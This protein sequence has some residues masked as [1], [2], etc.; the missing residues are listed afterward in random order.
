MGFSVIHGSPQHKWVPVEPGEVI[1][2]GSIVGVD[3]ATP[4]EGVQPLPSASGVSNATNAD[5]PFGI[6]VG[7]NNVEGNLAYST[8]YNTEYITQVAAGDVY[9]STTQYRGVEGVFSKGDP[10]AMVKVAIID[11]TTV[12]RGQLYDTSFGT[13]PTVNTVSVASGSDGIGCSTDAATVAT[14]ANFSTIYARSGANMGIYRTLTSNSTTAHTWLK[15]MKSDM[16]VGDTAVILN[17]LRPYGISL[18]Q[19]DSEAQFVDVNAALSSDYFYVNVLNLDLSEAG[20]EFIDFQFN[21][22][23][24]C[25]TFAS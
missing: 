22:E 16:A 1:Y 7:N 6:V 14:I 19:I 12:I 9:G 13:A 24:F 5:I 17:G 10:Q 20:N 11:P 2:N 23:T 25:P 3:T 18:M 4:L 15:A 8:T 21:A